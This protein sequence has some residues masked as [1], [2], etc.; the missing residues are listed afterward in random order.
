M[1][2]APAVGATTRQRVSVRCCFT[3]NDQLEPSG[4]RPQMK[5]ALEGRAP[6]MGRRSSAVSS[7]PLVGA[8]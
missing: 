6:V 2:F 8:L 4:S 1:N 5:A 3:A 7:G